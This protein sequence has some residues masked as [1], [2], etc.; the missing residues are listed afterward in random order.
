M[1]V[2]FQQ[3]VDANLEEALE[4]PLLFSPI[5]RR[6]DRHVAGYPDCPIELRKVY[7]T[8]LGVEMR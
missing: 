2:V 4:N 5:E 7:K 6:G 1:D 8:P 3:C